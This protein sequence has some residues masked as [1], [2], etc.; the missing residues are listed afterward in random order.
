MFKCQIIFLSP[1]KKMCGCAYV[2]P[3]KRLICNPKAIAPTKSNYF[4]L[5]YLQSNLKMVPMWALLACYVAIVAC[6]VAMCNPHVLLTALGSVNMDMAYVCKAI[7]LR[8]I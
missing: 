3:P 5:I 2:R 6:Y 1:N 8:P 4:H 7:S